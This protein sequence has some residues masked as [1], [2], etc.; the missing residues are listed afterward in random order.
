MARDSN[1]QASGDQAEQAAAIYLQHH[2]LQKVEEN[3]RCKLGEVDLIMQDNS[4]IVFVEVRFRKSD[5]YGS[6]ASTVTTSKQNKLRKTALFYLKARKLQHA[7]VRF[8]VVGMKPDEKND[9]DY[10][11]RWIKNAF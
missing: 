9:C 4:C 2:G 5:R 11:Y 10:Q 8:D 7:A 3:F 6:A 1:T